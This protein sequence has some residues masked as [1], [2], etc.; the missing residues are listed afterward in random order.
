MIAASGGVA[1]T[2]NPTNTITAFSAVAELADSSGAP[3]AAS[4]D[5]SEFARRWCVLLRSGPSRTR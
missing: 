1:R 2:R 5:G 4:D 3:G